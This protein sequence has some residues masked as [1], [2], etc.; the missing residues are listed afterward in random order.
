[1]QA[2]IPLRTADLRPMK[3]ALVRFLSHAMF[4]RAVYGRIVEL[5]FSRNAKMESLKMFS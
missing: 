1:M 4:P 3:L 5:S 2:H